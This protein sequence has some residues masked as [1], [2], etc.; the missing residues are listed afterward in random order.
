MANVFLMTTPTDALSAAAEP[1][2]RRILQLLAPGPRTA[3]ELAAE[4]TSTRSATSQHLAVLIGAGLVDVV[5]NGR[6]RIY[7][8]RPD[9]LARLQQ[10]INS[11]WTGEL[12]LL[13]RDAERLAASR[14]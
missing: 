10:E 11:F 3:G 4:F 1:A 6:H 2:R 12:D 5:K 8:V 13:A 7:S 9:G 14:S